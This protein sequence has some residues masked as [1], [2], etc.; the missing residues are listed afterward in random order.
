MLRNAPKIQKRKPRRTQ[1]Y[2]IEIQ[3]LRRQCEDQ[4]QTLGKRDTTIEDLRIQLQDSTVN[5]R[6]D[7][8]AL[9]GM[10][11]AAAENQAKI[12]R[13]HSKMEPC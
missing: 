3:V 4:L 2:K 13:Q 11:N 7:K 12:S 1:E 8:K 6:I 9:D 10:Q 5:W